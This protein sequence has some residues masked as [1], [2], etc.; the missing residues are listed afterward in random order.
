MRQGD[1]GFRI[2]AEVMNQGREM[3]TER[4]RA[5]MDL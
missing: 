4:T 2:E 3:A 5:W 1:L